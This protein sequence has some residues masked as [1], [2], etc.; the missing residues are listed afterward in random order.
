MSLTAEQRT[1]IARQANA[2]VPPVEI[3]GE[4]GVAVKTVLRVSSRDILGRRR[5]I[6]P[7]SRPLP[8]LRTLDWKTTRPAEKTYLA[9]DRCKYPSADGCEH[10]RV[11]GYPYCEHHRRLCYTRARA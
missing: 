7:A 2:G 11:H 10:E 9:S 8:A 6:R 5:V 3:A 1:L 4:F